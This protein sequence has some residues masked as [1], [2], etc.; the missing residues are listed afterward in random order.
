M[1]GIVPALGIKQRTKYAWFLSSLNFHSSEEDRQSINTLFSN[2]LGS[3][4]GFE[5]N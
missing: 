1:P 5:E 3:I 4:K 2:D